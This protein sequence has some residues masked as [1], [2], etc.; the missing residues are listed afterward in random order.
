MNNNIKNMLNQNHD[1]QSK[2]DLVKLLSSFSELI[3]ADEYSK[4]SGVDPKTELEKL[5]KKEIIATLDEFKNQYNPVWENSLSNAT[6]EVIKN[7]F[8]QMETDEVMFNTLAANGSDFVAELGSID[9]ENIIGG[10]LNAAVAA[11]NNAS[12]ATVSFIK[13]VGFDNNKEIRMVDFSYT[14]QVPKQVPS[15]PSDPNS[16]LID[17][18]SGA[19]ES[20]AV[21]IKVPFI[22]V[23]NVPS[24]RIETVDIDFNVKL[25]SVYTKDTSSEFGLNIDASSGVAIGKLYNSK[26]KV[27]VSYKRTTSTGIRVEKEYSLNVKIKATNDEMP[28]GLEKVLGLLSA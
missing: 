21:A 16:P 8:G 12:L 15:D 6:A 9:F 23:L 4:V 18:P 24:L 14:K 19:T 13:A 22:S 3:G 5:T 20:R 17:D 2:T 27:S 28:A 7:I 25:N 1:N 26:F 10:P 11:Q